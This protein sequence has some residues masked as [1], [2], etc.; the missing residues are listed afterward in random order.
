MIL[1]CREGYDFGL[2]TLDTV[3]DREDLRGNT[4]MAMTNFGDHALHHLFP[5]IDN[6]IL[7]HLYDILFETLNEFEAECRTSSWYEIIKGQLQQLARIEPHQQSPPERFKS[8]KNN[9]I[10]NQNTKIE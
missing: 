9:N 7:P 6:G 1:Y 4:L 5:T 2:Y 10:K 8:K 3:I